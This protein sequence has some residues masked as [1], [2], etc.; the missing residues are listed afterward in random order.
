MV[1]FFF[2]AEDGIRDYKVTGVQTCALPISISAANLK[3][4]RFSAL[5]KNK[6]LL[7]IGPGLGTHKETQRYVR[8][9]V[10]KAE[11]PLLL[12]ADGLNAFA[13]HAKD[14]AKRKSRLLALTPHPGEMA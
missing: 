10:Q 12:D 11:Q 9:L 1:F 5:A 14:L 2:Q 13:G 7:A 4:G 8:S 6:T 3:A